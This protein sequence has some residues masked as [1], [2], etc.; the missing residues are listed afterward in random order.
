L[1]SHGRCRYLAFTSESLFIL[2]HPH[3]ADVAKSK[4]AGNAALRTSE[5]NLWQHIAALKQFLSSRPCIIVPRV[6]RG[7]DLRCILCFDSQRVLRVSFMTGLL[8]L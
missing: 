5:Y 7:F 1:T 4:A 2:F 3:R 6:P 8:V